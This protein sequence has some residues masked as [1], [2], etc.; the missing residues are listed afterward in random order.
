MNDPEEDG[1]SNTDDGQESVGAS[2]ISGINA[3]ITLLPRDAHDLWGVLV[4]PKAADHMLLL[5]Y[6]APITLTALNG[7]TNRYIIS[8][9]RRTESASEKTTA[10]PSKFVVTFTLVT[11]TGSPKNFEIFS[12]PYLTYSSPVE[13]RQRHK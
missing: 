9:Y 12:S 3:S 13:V 8:M 4:R 1:C 10:H 6:R 7:P 11:V 2:V 5:A